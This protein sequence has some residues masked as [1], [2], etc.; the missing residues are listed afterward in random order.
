MK[1]KTHGQT[2]FDW[3]DELVNSAIEE[4]GAWVAEAVVELIAGMLSGL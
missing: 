4:I 3:L 2:G 1:M